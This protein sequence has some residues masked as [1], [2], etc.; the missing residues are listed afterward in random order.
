MSDTY[1]GFSE[2]TDPVNNS[3]SQGTPENN[4]YGSPSEPQKTPKKKKGNGGKK[5]VKLICSFRTDS[6]TGILG[7]FFS[8]SF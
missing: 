4:G 2:N 6:R 1:Y 7:S 5:V 8:N 3:F